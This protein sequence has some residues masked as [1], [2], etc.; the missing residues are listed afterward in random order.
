VRGG[1]AMLSF[2]NIEVFL[3][4]QIVQLAVAC[5]LVVAY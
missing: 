4:N 5:V 3:K 2:E 1:V